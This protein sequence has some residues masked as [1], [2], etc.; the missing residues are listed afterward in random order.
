MTGLDFEAT[1]TWTKG[2]KCRHPKYL[3]MP[4]KGKKGYDFKKA[5][6]ICAY[7]CDAREDCFFADLFF[8]PQIQGCFLIGKDCGNWQ[9]N[10]KELYHMYKKGIQVK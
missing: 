1:G 3:E 4:F 6:Q 9:T 5:K 8:T 2:H 10:R 7:Y